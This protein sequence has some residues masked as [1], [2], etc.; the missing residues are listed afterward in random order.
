MVITNNEDYA[1]RIRQFTSIGYGMFTAKNAAYKRD[2][3]QDPDYDRHM[4]LGWN[5][6]MPKVCAAIAL[7]QLERMDELL[8]QRVA[9]ANAYQEIVSTCS[10]LVPQHIPEYATSS[11]WTYVVHLVHP[12]ITWHQF[13]DKYREFGGDGIY[14]PWKLTYMEPFYQNMNLGGREKFF[15]PPFYHGDLQKYEPGLCPVAETL[16]RQLFQFKT[17]Y[18]DAARFEKQV[19]ALR[20]TIA[21]FD[22]HV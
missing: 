22:Q 19:E 8:E 13:R 17:N 12:S 16:Q 3:I 2:D 1:N 21:Y 18:F 9:V 20:Q 6:Q 5:Y 11:Y 7:G 4:A 14:A 15:Q 10:W